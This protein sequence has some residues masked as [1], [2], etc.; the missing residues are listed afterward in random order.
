MT[1]TSQSEKSPVYG[2]LQKPTMV[3]FPGHLASIMFTSGCNF[4]CGFCHNAPLMAESKGGLP[5]EKLENACRKFKADWVSGIVISGGEP[6]LW[7]EQLLELIAFFRKFDFDIKLD[8]NGSRPRVLE[9]ALPR[10]DFVSMDVK[11]SLEQYKSLA[12]FADTD[13]IKESI[14]MIKK[15]PVKHEFRTTVI[16]SK[17]SD[18]EMLAIGK[19]IKGADSYI[20]QPFVPRDNLPDEALRNE[21]RTSPDR[22]QEL[23]EMLDHCANSVTA[24]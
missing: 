19:L 12:G 14:E 24:K 2:Y 10:V 1:T 3:D 18:A 4:R 9:K 6:T 15:G 16:E 17:H 21:P 7:D 11:C 23:R 22:L 5:W 20:L 13:K 8:T